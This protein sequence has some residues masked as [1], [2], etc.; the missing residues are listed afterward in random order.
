VKAYKSR[1]MLF[2]MLSGIAIMT[3]VAISLGI[4]KL[5]TAGQGW[6]WVFLVG[7]IAWSWYSY[8]RVP[9][10]INVFDNRI[11][12]RS[13]LKRSIIFPEQIRFITAWGGMVKIRH[14]RGT[15]LL[16]AQM[17]GFHDFIST[18]NS[19]NPSIKLKG[20]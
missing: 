17:D 8:L 12:F 14:T 1:H 6:F 18:V 10:Q 11:E 16:F 2:V 4:D 5:R 15:V 20:V 3:I 19:L 7:A 13:I 9:F